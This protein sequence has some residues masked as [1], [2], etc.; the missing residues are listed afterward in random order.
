MQAYYTTQTWGYKIF[1]SHHFSFYHVLFD[2]ISPL[3]LG[4]NIPEIKWFQKERDG[5]ISIEVHAE[6]NSEYVVKKILAFFDQKSIEFFDTP[7]FYYKI[8]TNL[9]QSLL[10]WSLAFEGCLAL[11]LLDDKS[12]A[13]YLSGKW[14]Y[15]NAKT[16]GLYL[17]PFTLFLY[18][19][20]AKVV[21]PITVANYTARKAIEQTT[22]NFIR[23][24][25][26]RMEEVQAGLEGVALL[27][28]VEEKTTLSQKS[29][30]EAINEKSFQITLP[31]HSSFFEV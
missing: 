21:H 28:M 17:S 10:S 3:A 14:K 20:Y 15:I 18:T 13:S 7:R 19:D 6:V 24:I 26:R 29:I 31:M 8:P 2:A 27:S 1:S 12:T 30:V 9:R 11:L 5:S 16:G 4:E 25:F 22:A 23:K